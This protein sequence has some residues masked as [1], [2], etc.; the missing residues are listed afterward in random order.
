MLGMGRGVFFIVHDMSYNVVQ[1][2][3]YVNE[4]NMQFE[5]KTTAITIL[6]HITLQIVYMRNDRTIVF[7]VV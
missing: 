3:M 2:I 5:I 7:L 6:L 4:N 1:Y